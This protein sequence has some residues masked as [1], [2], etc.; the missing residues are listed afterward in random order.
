QRTGRHLGASGNLDLDHATRERC[1]HF[2]GGLVTYHGNDGLVGFNHVA[3]GNH[4]FGHIHFVVTYVRY[5]HIFARGGNRGGG[6]GS[7]NRGGS[8]GRRRRSSAFRFEDHDLGTGGN[9]VAHLDQ[10]LFDDTGSRSRYF[11]G[12]FVTFHGN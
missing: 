9:L 8:L 1:R 3:H 4:D 7:S 11:H 12:G 6:S 10:D 2:N 5:V